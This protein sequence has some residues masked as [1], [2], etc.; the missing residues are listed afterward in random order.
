MFTCIT[1]LAVQSRGVSRLTTA[2]TVS[3]AT[4]KAA[5]SGQRRRSTASIS[6]SW[7]SRARGGRG[8]APADG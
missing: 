3:P 6:R 8:S 4:A 7:E 1:A 5:T 2:I